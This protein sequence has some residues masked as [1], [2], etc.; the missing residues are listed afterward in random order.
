MPQSQNSLF[1]SGPASSGG[2]TADDTHATA[3]SP[4]VTLPNSGPAG[5]Q[6]DAWHPA[7]YAHRRD[8]IVKGIAR[9]RQSMAA[10]N[11]QLRHPY[12][13]MVGDYSWTSFLDGGSQGVS[14]VVIVAGGHRVKLSWVDGHESEF[15]L[16]WLRDHSNTSFNVNTKQREV[17][18]ELETSTWNLVY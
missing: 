1:V 11:A 14:E 9:G 17:R 5:C 13:G 8:S 4:V 2:P 12:N 18:H 15:S 7:I 3:Q 16:K 6:T 10:V